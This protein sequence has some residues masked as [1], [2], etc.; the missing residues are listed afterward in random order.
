MPLTIERVSIA[1]LLKQ[2]TAMFHQE[3]EKLLIEK[4]H[5][6]TSPE[7]YISLLQTFYGF[8]KPTEEVAHCFVSKDVLPDIDERKKCNWIESD[9][10]ALGYKEVSPLCS[11][12]PKVN[13]LPQALGCMYVL[14]GSTLG[15]RVICKMLKQNHHL[16]TV[17][18]AFHFFN[19]YGEETGSKWVAFQQCINHFDM[20]HELIVASANETFSL[21]HNWIKQ[22]LYNE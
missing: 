8:Y 4:L 22:S 7:H 15:G 18:N 1:Q 17:T 5:T 21:F 12:I 20:D 13:S 3:A 2:E 16:S 9:L 6:I 10:K 14:E 19:G 11:R